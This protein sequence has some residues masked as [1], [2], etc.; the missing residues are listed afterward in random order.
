MNADVLSL[1]LRPSPGQNSVLALPVTAFGI[2]TTL[3]LSVIG[4][5][6]SFWGWSDPEAPIYQA[7]AAIALVLL[8]VPLVSLGGAA[9]RL[10]ARR[11]DERLSTLRLLGVSPG[12]V[13]FATV[14]ESV[15]VAAVGA[16]LGVVGHLAL[17]PL[18]G[19][20]PF[21]GE[22]LGFGA[23]V[24]PPLH[25][26]VVFL[27]VLVLAAASATLGLRR[28]VISPLGVRTR[29]AP[30]KVHWVRV[31]VA[32]GAVAVA[33][34]VIKAFPSIG[35][36]VTTII[37]LAGMFGAVLAVLNVLGPWVLKV[38]ATRQLRRAAVP[39]RLLAARVVL[40]SPKAAWRQVGGIAMA[41]FMAVFAG[42]GVAVMNVMSAAD[43][44]AADVALI[45][46]IRTGLIITLVGSFLMVAASVG[47][48]QA[49]DVLDQR[50]LHRSLHH[51][52]V[53]LE[54]VDRARRRAIMSP[55]LL[56]AVGSALCAGVLA[57]PLV[58]I[59]LITAPLSLLTIAS[60]IAIGIGVVWAST[61]ATRPLLAGAFRVG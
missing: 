5:A 36:L 49:S 12:G 25:I 6:Q 34:V 20:I 4:G 45:D 56:T 50:E 35:D 48:N 13:T 9:A 19:L 46:D 27:G 1:L 8:V 54:T 60:V 31:I 53:P 14:V 29:S 57:F 52:G 61:W 7:L 59:A 43:A 3:V 42:T 11:R 37:V 17:S 32:V 22:S 58:G 10:S 18:I 41:S 24:L 38:A 15:L 55:L 21:R 40:D 16:L 2:V 39:E 26:V 30:A 33:F 23:V 28:V 47:V 44:S 51:L